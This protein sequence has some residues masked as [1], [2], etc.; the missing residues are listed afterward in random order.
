MATDEESP[1]QPQRIPVG[2]SSCL[3]GEEVR[4]DGT[5]KRNPFVTEALSRYFE[6]VPV[7]PEV[8][9]GLST[10]RPPIRLEWD[11]ERV[12]VRGVRHRSIE[13][14]E[15][16]ADYG[17]RKGAELGWLSGYIL[18]S[19]SPSCGMERVKV[20]K[21]DGHPAGFSSAGAYARQ[22]MEQNPLLPVEEEG[23]LNDPALRE[24]FVCRVF[25]YHRWQ[26]LRAAGLTR[27]GLVGFH[28]DHKLLLMAHDEQRMREL[29]RLVSRLGEEGLEAVAQRYIQGFMAALARPA[30]RGR[31]ANVLYHLLGYLKGDLEESD[32][33]EA[34]TVIEQYRQGMVPLIVPVTLLRHHFRHAPDPY[35]ER[36]L[37]LY[38]S[39][40][41]LALLNAV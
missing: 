7:C 22:L 30:T 4:Y 18:K 6:Y 37:Y 21:E 3:L 11:G 34:V 13:V 2:V 1:P 8:A 29:G 24:G 39:P 31:H 20:Y 32:R 33:R 15:A 40:P 36:Q 19:K 23:R 38:W 27:G 35:V 12:R 28:A 25:C 26:R 17:R 10:P 5:H 16:M 14:T 41:D 9:I